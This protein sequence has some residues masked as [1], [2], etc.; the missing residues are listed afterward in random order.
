MTPDVD[1]LGRKH[2]PGVPLHVGACIREGVNCARVDGGTEHALLEDEVVHVTTTCTISSVSVYV[3]NL[4][5]CSNVK[6]P[7]ET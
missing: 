5:G 6:I 3:W 2:H 7:K 4:A 1:L